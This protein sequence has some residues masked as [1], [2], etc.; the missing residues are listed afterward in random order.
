MLVGIV[1][2][3]VAQAWLFVLPSQVKSAVI[4]TCA[5]CAAILQHDHAV[6]GA[7]LKPT[8]D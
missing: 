6:E 8:K 5:V 4:P 3:I 7:S 2:F 1:E